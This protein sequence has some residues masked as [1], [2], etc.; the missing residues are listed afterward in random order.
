MFN[1]LKNNN[2]ILNRITEKVENQTEILKDYNKVNV[3]ADLISG[4]ASKQA[5]IDLETFV[6]RYYLQN[7]LH[8]ANKRF[9]NMTGGQFQLILKDLNKAGKNPMRDLI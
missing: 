8:S 1:S 5:K 7:I 6:Q 2:G 4:S 3:I 9:E